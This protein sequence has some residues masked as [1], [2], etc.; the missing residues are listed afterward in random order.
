MT[1]L[2]EYFS[3]LKNGVN[4]SDLSIYGRTGTGKT[5]TIKYAKNRIETHVKNDKL[6]ISSDKVDI[7]YI[8]CRDHN[9]HT[10]V[11]SKIA[12]EIIEDDLAKEG[13][14]STYYLE[15]VLEH[16]NQN[17]SILIVILDE[18]DYL[19]SKK[20]LDETLY[21]LTDKN[22]ITTI[23]ISNNPSW[24]KKIDLLFG[25]ST[26]LQSK[27]KWTGPVPRKTRQEIA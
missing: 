18:I 3:S 17:D 22:D 23:M 19:Y 8:N 1:E 27:P 4:P 25:P 26:S 10:K 20:D 21:S 16:M 6:E 12:R 14:S 5:A 13:H 2:A 7:V 15:A 11:Y 9:S 24:Q